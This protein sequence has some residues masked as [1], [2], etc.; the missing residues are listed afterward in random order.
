MEWLRTGRQLISQHEKEL[1]LAKTSAN[2]GLSKLW[3]EMPAGFASQLS[4][5]L[6]ISCLRSVFLVPLPWKVSGLK[7]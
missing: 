6:G 2:K 4:V 3:A 7:H 5:F 1:N